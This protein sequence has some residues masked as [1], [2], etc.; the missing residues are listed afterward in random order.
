MGIEA[1]DQAQLWR[2]LAAILHLGNVT[3]TGDEEAEL[4]KPST[5]LGSAARLLGLAPA[6]IAATMLQRRIST[7][8]EVLHIQEYNWRLI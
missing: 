8:S 1:V 5:A 7:G 4:S 6:Q 3:F 2:V